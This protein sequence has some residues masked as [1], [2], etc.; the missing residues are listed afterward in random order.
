MSRRSDQIF[1]CS[2]AQTGARS[3]PGNQ[4]SQRRALGQQEAGPA[5]NEILRGFRQ[6]GR[7]LTAARLYL[8]QKVVPCTTSAAAIAK[9]KV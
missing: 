2:L 6:P 8:I 3:L 5:V 9:G 7:D 1:P 4:H